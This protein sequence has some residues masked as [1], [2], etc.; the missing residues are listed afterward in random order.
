MVYFTTLARL[1]ALDTTTGEEK[2]SVK[3]WYCTKT[4]AYEDGILFLDVGVDGLSYPFGAYKARSGDYVWIALPKSAFASAALG[5]Q[6]VYVGVVND[7]FYALDKKTG[8]IQWKMPVSGNLGSGV[9]SSA[10]IAD[11]MVYFG[12]MDGKLYAVKDE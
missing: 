9:Y 5:K 1:Y 7:G 10:T 4:P 3:C 11:G 2:W 6:F 12:G 8:A